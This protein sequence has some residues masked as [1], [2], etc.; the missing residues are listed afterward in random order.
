[1]EHNNNGIGFERNN[2]YRSTIQT[3]RSQASNGLSPRR[4]VYG[5]SLTPQPRL[6]S[7]DDYNNDYSNGSLGISRG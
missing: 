2:Q 7:N 4:Y 1:M 5:G 6:R 3:T